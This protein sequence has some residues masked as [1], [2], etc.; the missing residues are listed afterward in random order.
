MK[1]QKKTVYK[2]RISKPEYDCLVR[3]DLNSIREILGDFEVVKVKYHWWMIC[4]I[5]IW[6]VKKDIEDKQ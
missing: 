1:K 2:F 6:C 5:D 4:D 3:R